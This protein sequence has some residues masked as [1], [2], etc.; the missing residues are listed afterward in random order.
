GAARCSVTTRRARAWVGVT[1]IVTT[2]AAAGPSASGHQ[3]STSRC[4]GSTSSTT[5]RRATP[6][7]STNRPRPPGVGSS[8]ASGA[9]H[10]ASSSASEIAFH[11]ASGLTSRS[12]DR[13]TVGCM[14][15]LYGCESRRARRI[16]TRNQTV[17]LHAWP[18][19]T[20]SVLIPT[21]FES[22]PR[23][24]RLTD[25]YSRLL[26]ARIVFL[27]SEIND[28]SANLV[29]AQLLH[30]AADHPARDINLYIN[31]PGGDMTGLF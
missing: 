30:L 3:R 16:V 11:R 31:S 19:G 15:Q 1:T 8:S 28:A 10:V 14:V 24:D 12:T 23:G 5:A 7:S 22:T 27:G 17:A 20:V 2:L 21:V 18:G 13:S 25:L 9:N 6:S 29:V 26:A 4:P